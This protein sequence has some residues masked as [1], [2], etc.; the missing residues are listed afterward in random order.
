MTLANPIAHHHVS[1]L[2]LAAQS[3]RNPRRD[4]A[5]VRLLAET[6]ARPCEL[7]SMTWRALVDASGS[8]TARCKWQ[9]AKRGAV[10]DIP[11]S[12]P[13]LEA[14]AKLYSRLAGKADLDSP[15]FVSERRNAFKAQSMRA[16]LKSL[17]AKAGLDASGYSLRHLAFDSEAKAVIE[18]GGTGQDLLNFS[19]HKA[20]TSVQPYL[21]RHSSIAKACDA[22]RANRVAGY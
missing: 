11:L 14:I 17:A 5:L 7:A 20:L 18:E 16:H 8:L 6:G 10:R 1:R 21:D 13:T 9:T 3:T 12:Q 22:R 2:I 15:V 19:G 4:V